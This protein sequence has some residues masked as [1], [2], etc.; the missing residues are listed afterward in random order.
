MKRESTK[1]REKTTF[2]KWG[3][4]HY[5]NTGLLALLAL[6]LA[7]M[8]RVYTA[9]ATSTVDASGQL[10]KDYSKW[11]AF[12]PVSGVY[13]VALAI[14]SGIISVGLCV[15][16]FCVAFNSRYNFFIC[17]VAF[18]SIIVTA[19]LSIFVYLAP[20]FDN[21]NDV[22]AL[23]EAKFG[24]VEKSE[25]YSCN[26]SWLSGD[27]FSAFKIFLADFKTEETSPYSVSSEEGDIPKYYQVIEVDGKAHLFST[28]SNPSN[29]DDLED[30]GP[31]N[32]TQVKKMVNLLAP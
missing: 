20:I 32:V 11:F 2:P 9:D 12:E 3:V 7:G 31:I 18:S 4:T 1:T 10:V 21:S 22:D 14:S 5:V 24:N 16:F 28:H 25:V 15:Y 29:V 23:S 13:F 17:A 8:L 6:S 19:V 27:N 30:R 26:S